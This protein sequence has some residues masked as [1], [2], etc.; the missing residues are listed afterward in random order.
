VTAIVRSV[1]LTLLVFGP[2]LVEARLAAHNESVQRSRGGVEPAGD[3]Y[4]WMRVAYPAAFLCM[5]AEGFARGDGARWLAVG[6]TSFALAK[7]LKWWA[8]ASLGRRWTFRVIVVPGDTRVTSGPY[9]VARHPNYLAVIG[10]LLG[11]ALTT[12]A[13]V[14]GPLGILLFGALVLRRVTVEDRALD[15]ILRAS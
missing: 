11:V 13:R 9:R 7:A 14:S 8:I 1:W 3:L 6:L 12:D 15:A 2:M 10:E 4:G 5:I